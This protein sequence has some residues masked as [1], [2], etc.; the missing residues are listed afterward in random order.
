MAKTIRA[1]E[2]AFAQNV[3]LAKRTA[4]GYS[5]KLPSE[6]H[7]DV[8]QA[9]LVGL[10]EAAIAHHRLPPD[11]FAAIAFVRIRGAIVD[12]L[13]TNDWLPRHS[14][15]GFAAK[16]RRVHVDAHEN[17][18]AF[19]E[20]SIWPAVDEFLD[21]EQQKRRLRDVVWMLPAPHRAVVKQKL[22]GK[23]QREIGDALKLS[24]ARISH[25]TAES[26]DCL[27][28]LLDGLPMPAKKSGR[29]RPDGPSRHGKRKRWRPK[30][31][32]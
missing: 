17:I 30:R 28:N 10:W 24:Q 11:E 18:D 16:F 5:R 27:R 26:I 21:D 20:L 7:E 1:A 4:F 9:A 25:L 23:S 29:F 31:Q 2:S 19:A 14:R 22:E 3:Q 12:F 15:K 13:R 6:C 32:A 8:A